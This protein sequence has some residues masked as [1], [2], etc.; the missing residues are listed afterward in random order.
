MSGSYRIPLRATPTRMMVL[1]AIVGVAVAGCSGAS[2]AGNHTVTYGVTAIT[3]VSITYET[4]NQGTAQNTHAPG[5]WTHA[6]SMS[7]GDF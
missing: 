5:N 3:S 6:E 4:G 2:S 1:L 7:G